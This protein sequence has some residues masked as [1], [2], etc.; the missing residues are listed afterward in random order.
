MTLS[1]ANPA[2]HAQKSR[3]SPLRGDQGKRKLGSKLVRT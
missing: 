1:E 2:L 3:E